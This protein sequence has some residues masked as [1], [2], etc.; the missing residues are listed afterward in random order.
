MYG[1]DHGLDL[2]LRA[3]SQPATVTNPGWAAELGRNVIYSQLIQKITALSA[4]ASL[5]E[6]R[7]KID[8][9][10]LASVT[11]PGRQFNP[12]T[13]GGWIAEGMPTPDRKPII[14][15]GPKLE[16]RK[17]A[18]MTSY[19]REMVIADSIEEFVTAAI[20]EAAAA[21]LDQ[22]MF[23]TNPGDATVPPGILV[24]AT[25]V[26]AS[27][28]TEPWAISMDIG[29]LVEALAQNGGGLEP[30]II[31]APAQAAALRMWR[32]ED[33]Y[34][35]YASLALPSGTV[36][37]V[38]KSSFVSGLEGVPRFE[39]SQ[40]ATYHY[41]DTTP[42]DIVSGGVSATPTKSLFQIDTVSLRVV[43][44]AAWGMRNPAHVAIM[45]D[46]TW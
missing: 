46:V 15:P 25:T 13:A 37:A 12:A 43:L 9:T 36:V 45:S 10:G 33:F 31:A 1:K 38:E 35:I 3:T 27:A 5:M 19:T 26:P 42:Q 4:A 23:S 18:V 8:L 22:A 11:I 28:A 30:A 32:Q 17:L 39:S 29:A 40:N 7:L 16:P 44:L 34:E 41:E 24:G 21:L 20:K 2:L 6:V 14:I